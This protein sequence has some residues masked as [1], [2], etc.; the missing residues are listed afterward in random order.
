ML[1]LAGLCLLTDLSS[2]VS[3][4]ILLP[5]VDARPRDEI[6][7]LFEAV[8]RLGLTSLSITE[9]TAA[10]LLQFGDHGIEDFLSDGI[11][12][13]AMERAGDDVKRKLS[14]VK[15]RHTKHRLVGSRPR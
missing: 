13:L 2:L 5:P 15:T 3:A 4:V 12:H 6:F 1:R 7:H 9:M 14:V 8:R 10:N 11:I